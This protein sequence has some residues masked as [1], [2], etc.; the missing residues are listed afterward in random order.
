VMRSARSMSSA[1]FNNMKYLSSA[2]YG[3]GT[4]TQAGSPRYLR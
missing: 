3:R 1:L 2:C 4:I